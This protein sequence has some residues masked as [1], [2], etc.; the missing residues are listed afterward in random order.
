MSI[1]FRLY[2]LGQVKFKALKSSMEEGFCKNC[3]TFCPLCENELCQ[4][5]YNDE[6]EKINNPS[7]DEDS[8][9]EFE[10]RN[11]DSYNDIST[12]Y[13]TNWQNVSMKFLMPH[14]AMNQV[15]SYR[16]KGESKCCVICMEQM[17]NDDEVVTLPC[18][19]T[20]H[21]KCISQWLNSHDQCPVCRTNVNTYNNDL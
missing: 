18:V 3:G 1:P 13:N 16:F 19:H 20:F 5:C 9:G 21:F 2:H 10:D 17:I 14:F 12:Q 11:N 7:S 8:I 6:I 15:M 4:E